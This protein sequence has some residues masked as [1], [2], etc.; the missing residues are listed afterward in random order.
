MKGELPPWDGKGRRAM[1]LRAERLMDILS[2]L[3]RCRR[4]DWR[5]GRRGASRVGVRY[6]LQVRADHPLGLG[7]PRSTEPARAWL[8]DV[9]ASGVGLCC[10]EPLAVGTTIRLVLVH[11]GSGNGAS[12]G[13]E[14]PCVVRRCVPVAAGVYHVGAS[15]SSL[16][17][18]HVVT[19]DRS[20]PAA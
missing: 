6:T 1:L 5:G 9:S 10:P 7:Q 4:D 11:S 18:A 19:N 2:E 15:F 3:K 16:W 12:G 13:V 20:A 17:Q 8:R 14:V